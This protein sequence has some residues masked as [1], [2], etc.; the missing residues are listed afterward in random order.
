M[1]TDRLALETLLF[2]ARAVV[3]PGFEKILNLPRH[4]TDKSFCFKTFIARVGL[5]DFFSK[6][7]RYTKKI[8][9]T[10]SKMMYNRQRKSPLAVC[11]DSI[12]C[13]SWQ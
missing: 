13:R 1:V 12:Q 2:V 11:A 7:K 6:E 8:I 4:R 10:G 3:P 5:W 9:C